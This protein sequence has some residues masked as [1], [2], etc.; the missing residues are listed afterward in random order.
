MGKIVT[1]YSYKGGTGRSMALANVAWALASQG[2]S[3]LVI[4]WDLEA[5]GLHRYFSPFLADRHLM[6]PETHGVIEF[7]RSYAAQVA[8]PAQVERTAQWHEAYANIAKWG[9]IL[10]WPDGTPL[11]FDQRGSITLVPAG[12]QSTEYAERV[13]AFDWHRLY[14]DQSGGAFFDTVRDKARN[15]FDYVLIDSRTGVSD[16]SGICTIQMPDALVVCYTYNVQSIEG[17]SDI[18]ARVREKRPELSIFPVAM[19]VEPT[20]SELLE[21]MRQYAIGCFGGFVEAKDRATY[22]DEMEVPYYPKYAFWE[23]LAAFED[24]PGATG[25]IY[26]QMN[27]LANLIATTPVRVVSVP[28]ARK[29]QVMAI[30]RSVAPSKESL[31]PE[32][33]PQPFRPWPMVWAA[34][35]L[36]IAAFFLLIFWRE[37]SPGKH[38]A[39]LILAAV[40]YGPIPTPSPSASSPNGI[41]SLPL[42][43]PFNP[44]HPSSPELLGTAL[45]ETADLPEP[46]RGRDLYNVLRTG[47]GIPVAVVGSFLMP[48]GD[49][50][51]DERLGRLLAC[52]SSGFRVWRMQTG[53]QIVGSWIQL[54]AGPLSFGFPTFPE[55]EFGPARNQV[56]VVTDAG[57]TVWDWQ[58]PPSVMRI[59]A[60]PTM[61]KTISF[62]S[63]E[64][65]RERMVSLSAEGR[66]G[67]LFDFDGTSGKGD[68]F[69]WDLAGAP[70]RHGQTVPAEKSNAR[71][72]PPISLSGDGIVVWD[73]LKNGQPVLRA[74]D[75]LTGKSTE[76]PLPTPAPIKAIS[77][78]GNA[79]MAVA[80]ELRITNLRNGEFVAS[81]PFKDAVASLQF[82]PDGQ[83]LAVET[84]TVREIR[85]VAS[86]KVEWSIPN[87]GLALPFAFGEQ[88]FLSNGAL[89]RRALQMAPYSEG[90]W[91]RLMD[92]LRAS[93]TICMS[94]TDRMSIL[95][96]PED[97]ARR[98]F[99][100]CETREGRPPQSTIVAADLTDANGE[101]SLQGTAPPGPIV[102]STF[103]GNPFAVSQPLTLWILL[104][105][106]APVA[107]PVPP[108]VVKAGLFLEI[109]PHTT[110]PTTVTPTKNDKATAGIVA[111]R[112]AGERNKDLRV[113]LTSPTQ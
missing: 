3:V 83:H 101:F 48:G 98:T 26:R 24:R 99:E 89:Y 9:R 93:T 61:Q 11:Q 74:T 96:E 29:D 97:K 90:N 81:V 111:G 34:A 47:L 38:K 28:P 18:A 21:Q 40:G 50:K 45:L 13:N 109:A 60:I 43:S 36:S 69:V 31:A 64:A 55:C 70:E 91:G 16:T 107:Y 49:W 53:Q 62:P 58:D 44:F 20:E 7:V 23:R 95:L 78:N 63:P 67:S 15:E 65:G 86:L 33:A 6:A 72:A 66:G 68:G 5:P 57:A 56:V 52:D 87:T 35:T 39:D 10:S 85:T 105:G 71:Y 73:G 113:V 51:I 25:S 80:G 79:A 37:P 2:R 8:T 12:R 17:A 94:Q 75:L 42:P 82:S 100:A 108:D 77:S 46:T 106:S 112:V 1:F 32:S 19:R 102:P 27:Q 59:P 41:P 54:N 30:F 110:G 88:T 76:I 104:Q 14:T 92:T 84:M 22:F 103:V 4:D